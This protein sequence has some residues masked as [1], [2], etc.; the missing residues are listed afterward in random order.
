MFCIFFELEVALEHSWV[1]TSAPPQR[2]WSETPTWG[3]SVVD[4]LVRPPSGR[5]DSYLCSLG[6]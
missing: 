1:V 6:I 5:D 4:V 2:A 3:R